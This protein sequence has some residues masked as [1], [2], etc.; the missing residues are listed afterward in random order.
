M[1][2]LL[3][4]LFTISC[5][6][7]LINTSLKTNDTSKDAYYSV[8]YK[9]SFKP[10]TTHKNPRVDYAN[11]YVKKDSS[12]FQWYAVR[13]QDS[14]QLHRELQ[15][16]DISKFHSHETF[17]VE[18]IKDSLTYY[19]DIGNEEYEYKEKI[20]YKWK[21][22]SKTKTILGYKCKNAFVEYGG[23][24][25]EAWYTIEIPL[26]TGPYKF[27]GLPGLII[28][29]NDS[30]Y[31]YDFEVVDIKKKEKLHLTKAYHKVDER[32]RIKTNRKDFNKLKNMFKSLSFSDRISY[33]NR[34]KV[35]NEEV[36]F[37]DSN[38][39]AADFRNTKYSKTLNLIEIDQN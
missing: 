4:S 14:I 25:W 3:I 17:T 2:Y 9:V 11:L 34:N 39:N 37:T 36:V 28:K 22:G 35:S 31:S 8:L 16:E 23:R 1:K 5:F 10:F 15:N 33:M 12:I 20:S 18:F 6:Y 24:N 38:G 32:G 30:T 26:N 21:L 27:K 19:D 29:I 7:S 13:K